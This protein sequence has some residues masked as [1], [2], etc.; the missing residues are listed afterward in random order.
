MKESV[1]AFNKSCYSV[2]EC[3]ASTGSFADYMEC[4]DHNN[5][6][7]DGCSAKCTIETPYYRCLTNDSGP[8][9]SHCTPVALDGYL[10]SAEVCDCAFSYDP[11][12]CNSA[13]TGCVCNTADDD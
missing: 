2:S 10:T 6:D 9:R 8:T 3:N 5:A 4:W 1:R 7:G 12:T 11:T 13:T